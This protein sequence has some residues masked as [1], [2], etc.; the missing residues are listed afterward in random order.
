[1]ED[2]ADAGLPPLDTEAAP[3]SAVP[4]SQMWGPLFA[5]PK[6]APVGKERDG[7]GSVRPLSPLPRRPSPTQNL[8]QLPSHLPRAPAQ[9]RLAG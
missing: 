9:A 3:G 2:G 5:E 8:P 4:P 6:L 1:M 7:K